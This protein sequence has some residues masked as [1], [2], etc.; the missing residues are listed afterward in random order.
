MPRIEGTKVGILSDGTE[1]WGPVVLVTIRTDGGIVTTS[2][3]IDSGADSTVVP[4]EVLAGLGVDFE[5][6]PAGESGKG[7]GGAFERR[8]MKATLKFRDWTI[9]EE[10]AVAE[11]GRLP[12]VLLGRLD[13]FQ[14][15]VVRFM[16][17]KV[18]PYVDVD[19]IAVPA[20]KR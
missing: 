1:I 2:A 4:C 5:K 17:H 11:P 20:K 12:V 13:F 10:I 15:F 9:C 7:A 18:P 14:R 16:W 6:L 3:I 8:P 19:P